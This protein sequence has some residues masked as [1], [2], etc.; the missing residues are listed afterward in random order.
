MGHDLRFA[1]RT[2]ARSPL[3][4]GVAVLS[5]ALGIG[6]NTSIFSLLDQVLYRSLPV[7][8]PKALV[9]FHADDHSSGRS[10]S[11]NN[12]SVFSYPMYRDLSA[13]STVFNGV[14]A[15]AGVPVSVSWNGQTERA[16]AEI[17]SGNLF[18]ALG[19]SATVGRTITPEDDGAPGAHP[20]VMLSH[21]Y[22]VRRFAG[23]SGVLNVKVAVNGHPMI[24]IGI[25]PEGFRGVLSGENPEVFVPIAMK[26][27]VTPTWDGLA[28][29]QS[30]WLNIL[31]RLKPGMSPEQAQA[32]MQTVYRPILEAQVKQ[33]PE[34]S[35]RA[36]QVILGQKLELQPAA[37]GIN[38]LRQEW[39]N[40]LAAL[41]ALV[42]L[43]LLIACANVANLLLARAASRHREMAIRLALGAARRS[44]LQQLLTESLVIALAGGLLGLLVSVWTTSALLRI[45]PADATGGWIAATL[46]VRLLVFTLALS[47]F[48]GLLFGVA[49]ALQASRSEVASTLRQQSAGLE[50]AGGGARIRRVLV[51]VQLALSLLLLVGAGLFARSLFNLIHV[52]P[53][54]RTERLLTFAIDP[55]L[56]GYSKERGFA[57]F[58]DLQERLARLPGVAAAGAASPGPLTNSNRG[59]NVT[60]EGYQAREDEDMDVSRHAVGPGYFHALGTPILRGREVAPRDLTSP[61][62]VVVVNE[63]FVRRFF[64]GG[65]PL[66]RHM[67]FGASSTRLPDREI[68]GV[69]RDFKHGSLRETPKPAVYSTYT[70]E[71][72]LDRMEFYVRGD[73]DT[74]TLGTQVRRLVQQMDAGLPVFDMQAVEI[75]VAASIEIDRLIAILSCAFGVLATVLAG[76]GLYGLVAYTVERRTAEIGIRVALGAVPRDVL[77]LV[78]KD[79]GMLVIF[80]LA[81][82]LPVA[83]ALGRLVESQLFG[84]K[85]A[86]PAIYAGAAAALVLVAALS[87]LI[88]SSRAAR[89]D[90]IDALRHE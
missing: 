26:R 67:M 73:R 71:E 86:D 20:V 60:V 10:S 81:I 15:R 47:I 59:G 77:L 68:V 80:G 14:V 48:T 79:V 58:H 29:R 72:S 16:S 35:K 46:D 32:A 65:N 40:P 90:P 4:T 30:R 61:D 8:D 54:F 9:V 64:G 69:V 84:L 5:L 23:E 42:G 22:W 45:L 44:L 57:L 3:F 74:A 12:Q 51:V 41:M 87:G 50:S 76:I 56:N 19:V 62:K 7:R 78:M 49:P 17:V 21:D 82:G 43:V 31:A 13:G 38:Q 28:D 18:E 2:L 36:N 52:D 34:H 75:Q 27:E 66:G 1:L 25:A 24:V 63:A 85:A 83:L 89:I 37:Q 70:N 6:A 39:E 11:D 88:P 53:G 33:F 55:A